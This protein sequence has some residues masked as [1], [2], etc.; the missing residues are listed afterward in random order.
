MPFLTPVLGEGSPTKI[1]YRQKGTLILSSLL[2]D[3]IL[4]Q[5][6][7]GP[8]V[9]SLDTLLPVVYFSRGTLPPK[10]FLTQ[11]EAMASIGPDRR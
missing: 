6:G 8:P 2:E 9:E 4:Y 7:L 3:L 1:D 5:K 10:P 11:L